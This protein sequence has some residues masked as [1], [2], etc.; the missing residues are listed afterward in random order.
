[1]QMLIKLY[2]KRLVITFVHLMKR[3]KGVNKSM[4]AVAATGD[5]SD[6]MREAS[7]S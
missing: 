1:M 3:L 4:D 5:Y 2:Y 7:E 6:Q